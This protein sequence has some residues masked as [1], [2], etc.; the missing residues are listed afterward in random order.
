ML[1]ILSV[2]GENELSD[3]LVIDRPSEMIDLPESLKEESFLRRRIR[4]AKQPNSS[5]HIAENAYIETVGS[6]S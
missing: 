6:C 3:M 4:V 5:K 2:E 1:S